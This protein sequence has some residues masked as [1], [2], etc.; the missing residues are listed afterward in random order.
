MVKWAQFEVDDD[1]LAE[2]ILY[3]AERSEGDPD[4][5]ATKINKILFYADF[6]SYERRGRPITGQEYM[7]LDFGPAPRRYKP[8]F[9][10]LQK[11]GRA[12][13]QHRPVAGGKVQQR[14]IALE[15][16]KL[17]CFGADE[18]A[19]VDEV[20]DALRGYNASRASELSHRFLGWQVARERE[21][22]PYEMVYLSTRPLTDDEFAYARELAQK[23]GL[24]T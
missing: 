17:T 23:H 22:I 7:R 10:K 13:V 19:I 2:L 4:F 3:V 24:Q 12:A 16:P 11:A 9:A 18:I 6:I 1:K 8:V 5:G 15:P 14:T 21:T 20:I